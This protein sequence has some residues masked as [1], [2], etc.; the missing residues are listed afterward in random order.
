MNFLDFI[1][2]NISLTTNHQFDKNV[3]NSIIEYAFQKDMSFE[4]HV[5][6][7][8]TEYLGLDSDSIEDLLTDICWGD[9]DAFKRITNDIMIYCKGH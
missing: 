6:T 2:F 1:D 8:Y 5:K 7:F 9:D 4:K 3:W